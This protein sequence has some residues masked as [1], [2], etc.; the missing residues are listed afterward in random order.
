MVLGLGLVH[1]LSLPN[2]DWDENVAIFGVDSSSSVHTDHKKKD[3][4]NFTRSL[5]KLFEPTS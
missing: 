3:I 4:C 2:F 5:K 1:F